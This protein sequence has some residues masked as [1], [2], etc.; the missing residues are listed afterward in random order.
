MGRMSNDDTRPFLT[1]E[2]AA[3]LAHRLNDDQPAAKSPATED[4]AAGDDDRPD[5]PV[6]FRTPPTVLRRP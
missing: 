4:E 1:T 3:S 5:E 6:P 2:V